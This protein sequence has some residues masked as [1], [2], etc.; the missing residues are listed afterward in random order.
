MI[1]KRLMSLTWRL[2]KGVPSGFKL[3][4]FQ[5]QDRK[6]KWLFKYLKRRFFCLV[7][8]RFFGFVPECLGIEKKHRVILW[9]NLAAPSLGD[10][11]MDL[12]ARVLLKDR[13]VVLLTHPKNYLLYQNDSVFSAVFSDACQVTTHYGRS[14]FDLVI[15]DSYSPRVLRNKLIIAPVS[16]F[17]GLYG[18]L[19]G[20][21][22]HRTYFA[23]A[24]MME[25]LDLDQINEPMRPT[26][27]L[28]V[29]VK[30]TLPEF[31]VCISIGGE[32]SFRTYDHWSAVVSWLIAQGYSVSLVGSD[33][34]VRSASEIL[35]LEPTVR[36]TVGTLSL[37]E[38][39]A[40]IA[41]AKVFI[42]AD[43]GLWHIACAIP[44]PSVVLFADCQIFDDE[45]NRVTRETK[46]IICETLYD[47]TQV[48]NIQSDSVVEAFKRLSARIGLCAL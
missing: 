45:G 3:F 43:G 48:S 14:G 18:F 12:S 35:E 42:G 28:P 29:G 19:N 20:F 4:L 47:D 7:I 40:E 44:I 41:K 16:P 5:R 10:S 46:D 30:D 24:R 31:D 13:E 38:V 27:T 8:V 36:S 34:G 9:I 26:I 2:P 21:E 37:P 22:V 32:W 1:I 11:L 25:L 23:F 6:S 15:V 39:V 17:I 33:N